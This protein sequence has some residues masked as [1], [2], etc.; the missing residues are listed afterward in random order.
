MGVGRLFGGADSA[1][2]RGGSRW[3]S[4]VSASE[5]NGVL[6]TLE[7]RIEDGIGLPS[8][9][10]APSHRGWWRTASCAG[11]AGPGWG[12]LPIAG[13]GDATIDRL[14]RAEGEPRVAS[15]Y[16]CPHPRECD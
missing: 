16:R 5:K 15:T 12:P 6:V 3:G 4:R 13:D 10:H 7:G 8:T 1:S 14:M 2:R 11:L 9:R